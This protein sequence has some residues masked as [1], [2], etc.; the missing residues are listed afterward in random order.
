[1]KKLEGR[2]AIVYYDHLRNKIFLT[3]DWIGEMPFHYLATETG[4]YFANTLNAI[5]EDSG[6]DFR[7][8]N[9]RAFPQSHF[10]II[11]LK[12]IDEKNIAVPTNC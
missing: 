7:Y 3:R 5:K 12:D 4:F 11:E 1:M 6:N 2:F 10:Q 8:E 9:V